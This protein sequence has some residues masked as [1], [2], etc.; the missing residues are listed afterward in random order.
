MYIPLKKYLSFLLCS[1]LLL[2]CGCTDS[3]SETVSS[4]DD[5]I[6]RIACVGD[7][8]TQGI[9]ATGWKDG[10]FTSAYPQQLNQILGDNYKVGNFGKGSSYVYYYEGRTESLWYP[11]TVQYS[12]SNQFEADVVMILLGTND[13]R[14]MNN[15]ADAANWKT[16]FTSL[17]E[18]Y[19]DLKTKPK[20]YIISSITLALYDKTKEQQLVE[21]ILPIQQE[22]ARELNCPF[23]DLYHG[24]YDYFLTGEGFASD[25]LHPNDAGYRKI[26]EYIAEN[27]DV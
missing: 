1:S 4:K 9:G 6:I 3:K 27:V 17:V 5:S 19:L 25:N 7:S 8:I 21:Y 26:A 11:N 13:A 14:V 16:E 23:I 20:V 10:D 22:V 18:H 12:L 24:L 15:Q 2:A